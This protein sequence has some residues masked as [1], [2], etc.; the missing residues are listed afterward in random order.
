ML[1]AAVIPTLV[2]LLFTP[3]LGGRR[4]VAHCGARAFFL[5]IGSTPRVEGIGNLP[6]E[7]CVVVANHASYLDGII[8]KAA[9]SSEIHLPDQGRDDVRPIG[10]LS[11][12]THRVGVRLPRR[13]HAPLE[14]R[15][16]I[17]QGRHEGE[18]LAFFPEGTFDGKPGLKPFL[19]GAFAAAWRAKLPV[20]PVVIGGS[21]RMLPAEV[22]LC[23]PGRLSITICDPIDSAAQGSAPE[24][25]A[26]TRQ[27]MLERLD[28]PDL[29]EAEQR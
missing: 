9:A 6:D 7:P 19:P 4:R 25:A 21:R 2:L 26:A 14:N 16:T 22:W 1:A 5:L 15:P 23:A 29:E 10:R 28:E 18:S 20:V 27:S 12:E 24:L 13:R 8:L 11:V 17:A 3:T